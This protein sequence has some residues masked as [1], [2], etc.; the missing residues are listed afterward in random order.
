MWC[1]EAAKRWFS[2]A[3]LVEKR[4]GYAVMR[5]NRPPVNSLN[6]ELLQSLD[7]TLASLE[8]DK[9]IKGVVLASSN[10][11]IFSAGLDLLELHRPDTTRLRE[12]W[13]SLQ[14]LYMRLY[15]SPLATVA[16]IEGHSPAG[17]CAL[18]MGCDAR[19]M[20]TGK[21]LI[22][23]NEAKFGLVAPFWIKNV[24]VNL[25]GHRE[26][27]RMLGLGL[28]V[29]A[30][31]A[32]RIGLVD[33]AVPHELVLATAEATLQEWLAIPA[34]ARRATKD[35]VRRDTV[36]Q[37]RAN[38]QTDEDDVVRLVETESIQMALDKY[39]ASLKQQERPR[40]KNA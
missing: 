27:E 16:A 5:M 17:G 30:A 33:E 21:P 4:E 36:E 40:A 8:T 34:H 15:M 38:L 3:V 19:V 29:D 18:A 11:K 37:L 14:H 35:L 10:P 9:S 24:M 25:I 6:L 28:Q 39:L 1:R 32:K 7:A 13:R 26:S 31:T 20:A 12:F 23:M 22:G 2:T